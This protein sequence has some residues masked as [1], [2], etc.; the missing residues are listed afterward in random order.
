[1][2]VVS[3]TR[4][5]R[6]RYQR[7]APGRLVLP[8]AAI[9]VAV[10][11]QE[12]LTRSGVLPPS[13]FPPVSETITSLAAETTRERF[14]AALGSTVS[15]W[16][17]AIAIAVPLGTAVGMVLGVIPPVEAFLRPVIE[18]LRPIPSVALIPLV[19]LT[20]GTSSRSALFLAVFASFWQVLIP[21]IVGVRS[22]H[23]IAVD[24]ARS[25]SFTWSQR[26]RWVQLAAML[27][28]LATATRLATS[29]SLILI[30][31]AEIIIGVPGIGHEITMSRSAGDP[32]R[33][34]AY[35]VI[36]GVAGIVLNGIVRRVETMLFR[37][38]GIGAT[39]R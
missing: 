34:Y 8:V 6:T 25:Y 27:P 33:M 9:A 38:H 39:A 32:A 28:H 3:L 18:F 13:Y 23:P 35:I 17:L 26:I 2:A 7:P 21:A 15:T 24:T 22:A 36:S 11:A 1:M 16:L 30:V 29:T 19:V 12:L 5:I 31:T 4:T 14:W 10:V 20:I 37:S